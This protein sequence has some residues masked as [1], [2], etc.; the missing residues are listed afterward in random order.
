MRRLTCLALLF[1]AG[2]LPLARQGQAHPHSWIDLETELVFDDQ[3]RLTTLRQIWLF[4]EYYTAWALEGFDTDNDG[5]PDPA[6]LKELLEENLH[7][8]EEYHYF[9]RLQRDGKDLD[10]N[11]VVESSSRMQGDRLR[12]QFDLPLKTPIDLS[13]TATADKSRFVYAVYDPTYYIEILHADK[14]GPVKLVNPPSPDCKAAIRK[15]NPNAATVS[16]AFAMD[17]SETAGDGLGQH[18]AE[19][20]TVTCP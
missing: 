9:T 15:P 1:C 12:M 14:A 19:K 5:K 4:D 18:F 7:N 13:G 16:L 6:L 2:L 17:K 8:L 20:V 11:K 10:S 3:G